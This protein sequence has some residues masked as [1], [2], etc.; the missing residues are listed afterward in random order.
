MQKRVLSLVLVLCMLL[1][2]VPAMAL[3]V[4]AEETTATVTFI[5]GNG[6]TVSTQTVTG[7]TLEFTVPEVPSDAFG[8][9]VITPAGAIREASAMIGEAAADVTFY[10]LEK[11]STFS[12]TENWPLY[13][14]QT[15]LN[16]YRGGW[17]AGTYVNNEYRLFDLV[18]TY[19][20]LELSGGN[21]GVWQKG[22][23][24]LG[25]KRMITIRGTA[26][27]LSYNAPATGEIDIDFETLRIDKNTDGTVFSD[28]AMAI[29]VNGV[30]VWP[31][32]AA[33]KPV[34]SNPVQG[35]VYSFPYWNQGG[36]TATSYMDGA[37]TDWAFLLL[38]GLSLPE[39][40]MDLSDLE[41]LD[42][43]WTKY[44][45]KREG[46]NTWAA[47]V[48]T[49]Q[50]ALEEA[51]AGGDATAI[52][53]A[54][55]KLD[56]A[57]LDL[58][59]Y[60]KVKALCRNV[61]AY[62]KTGDLMGN[63]VKFCDANGYPHDIK[64][65][66]G[67]RVDVLF[68]AVNNR[69]IT[70]YPTVTYNK[71]TSAKLISEDTVLDAVLDFAALGHDLVAGG[72]NWPVHE[73]VD[74]VYKKISGFGNGWAYGGYNDGTFVE[75]S[76]NQTY[77]T[78]G[79]WTPAILWLERA[80]GEYA[81][82]PLQR[83]NCDG[84]MTSFKTHGVAFAYTAA[85]AG[86]LDLNISFDTPAA[87][88]SQAVYFSVYK[89]AADGSK[90]LIYPYDGIA[91]VTV[92]DE[93]TE[94]AGVKYT[95]AA[96]QTAVLNGVDVAKGDQLVLV[97]RV[98][99]VEKNYTSYNSPYYA[100]YVNI[101]MEGEP[102][103][104]T[105]F[106]PS[107][108][109]NE[110]SGYAD[111]PMG[112]K[113][114]YTGGWD[115]VGHPIAS[116]T[117]A[118]R[119]DEIIRT[120]TET[121]ATAERFTGYTGCGETKIDWGDKTPMVFYNTNGSYGQ[122][123]GSYGIIPKASHAAGLR[124]TAEYNG[125]VSI[126]IEKLTSSQI[127]GYAAVFVNGTMVWPCAEEPGKTEYFSL[128]V[129]NGESESPAK[130]AYID[131][132][133]KTNVAAA[134]MAGTV[135]VGDGSTANGSLDNIAVF[136]GDEI[137]LLLR[138]ETTASNFWN[139]GTGFVANASVYYSEKNG[140]FTS[141]LDQNLPA[142]PDN[143]IAENYVIKPVFG[144]SAWSFVTYPREILTAENAV[145]DYYAMNRRTEVGPNGEEI[146]T[147]W[148]DGFW[149][150]NFTG[151]W[152]DY[153]IG[154]NTA[155][156]IKDNNTWGPTLGIA[157]NTW[158][159]GGYRYT[160]PEAGK[161]DVDVTRL[162]TFDTASETKPKAG[163]IKVAIYIDQVKVWPAGEDWYTLAEVDTEYADDIAASVDE[164][165][166]GIIVGKNSAIDFLVQAE[167]TA[168][169]SRGTVFEGAVTYYEQYPVSATGA[170]SVGDSFTFEANATAG[171]AQNI[172]A[173]VITTAAKDVC[174]K[175]A[176]TVTGEIDGKT[177]T[178]A[179]GVTTMKDALMAYVTTDTADKA[180]N[181]A[182]A[183]LNYAAAAQQY[184]AAEEIAAADLAN[185][186]LSD[187]QK[188]VTTTG[189]YTAADRVA[190][191]ENATAKLIG[192]S[193]L[194]EEKIALKLVFDTDVEGAK[195]QMADNADF[196]GATEVAYTATKE[197]GYYK[198]ITEGIGAAN[199]NSLIYF[200]VVDADGVVISTTIAYSV[201]AYCNN[202][203]GDA[204]VAPVANAILALYDAANAYKNA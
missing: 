82:S 138:L 116:Y 55:A 142:A 24:Y 160:A 88:E 180:S 32:S 100:R 47:A 117:D 125:T 204:T 196:T 66:A 193:L 99:D 157:I 133:D 141:R 17:A 120:T 187:A 199:Y 201:A 109:M 163:A 10:L 107:N 1:A 149:S 179:T 194:L 112:S 46:D 155:F 69:H 118:K 158:A 50:A 81:G 58:E 191:V 185:A 198:A 35:T 124:Y 168:W 59:R 152:N 29:A 33:G 203:L 123:N 128:N 63:Y 40:Y 44:Q 12:P 71:V 34:S 61:T 11:T 94:G 114:T 16:G 188:T 41:A 101:A 78:Y 62:A 127:K 202:M 70:A 19:N 89:H 167:M 102:V 76:Y 136:A 45:G 79:N 67:D 153:G 175:F 189:E 95:T 106:N 110:P 161:I 129:A 38:D 172:K 93:A 42:F 186:G 85:G 22:G 183:S 9:Y 91:G 154:Q 6:T 111:L 126:N 52:A 25:D 103:Y 131:K 20:I 56:K 145:T 108:G 92:A 18:N 156:R 134:W 174:N 3:P 178:L 8:W 90:T 146:A 147:T 26:L 14:S 13:T 137:E 115:I 64:V 68:S 184:F 122:W 77:A 23:I 60:D 54:Q 195:V 170:V 97:W 98:Q 104:T 28:M 162:W 164:V 27:A 96:T 2:M 159:Y 143:S 51:K 130:W 36:N 5:D 73:K 72:V 119:I 177:V 132:T 84:S 139:N 53:E 190:E 39:E 171:I 57:T 74:S 80:N 113:V 169:E 144:D 86:E 15:S 21:N 105:T 165:L 75:T 121:D 135:T 48:T 166:S 173:D 49:A 148:D 31:Q 181:V 7:A 65:A 151:V 87:T 30:V 140:M 176:Y 197:G 150:A 182:I 200:R 83:S 192:I 43:D 37:S 4:F